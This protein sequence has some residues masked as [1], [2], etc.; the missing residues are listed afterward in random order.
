M[1]GEIVPQVVADYFTQ[2]IQEAVGQ[3]VQIRADKPRAKDKMPDHWKELLIIKGGT[4]DRLNM[5]KVR[6]A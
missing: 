4:P 1:L 6:V 2:L 5:S 3:D